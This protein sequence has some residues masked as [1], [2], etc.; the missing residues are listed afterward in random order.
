MDSLFAL[1]ILD[2]S[3]IYSKINF[4]LTMPKQIGL[5]SLERD[6]REECDGTDKQLQMD[7]IDNPWLEAIK[8]SLAALQQ[9]Q[10]NENESDEEESNEEVQEIDH[11]VFAAFF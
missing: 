2:N 1:F 4:I 6:G 10:S 11:M 9:F 7:E 3:S 5:K 8:T